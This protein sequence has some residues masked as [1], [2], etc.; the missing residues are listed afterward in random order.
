[1]ALLHH[2]TYPASAFFVSEASDEFS[3]VH[4]KYTGQNKLRQKVDRMMINM[5]EKAA[6]CLNTSEPRDTA[7]DI[8]HHV[9]NKIT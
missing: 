1:M 2:T 6:Y 4:P 5:Q 7:S 3:Q 9:H 8:A